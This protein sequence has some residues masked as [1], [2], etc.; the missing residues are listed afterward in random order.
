MGEEEKRGASARECKRERAEKRDVW[1]WR[2]QGGG[3][4][5]E[6]VSEKKIRCGWIL[7]C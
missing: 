6:D 2:R 1:F 5:K 7:R 3:E 4:R